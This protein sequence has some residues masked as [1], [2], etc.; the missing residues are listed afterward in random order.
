MRY[1]F[2]MLL[3]MLAFVI[4]FCYMKCEQ[5]MTATAALLQAERN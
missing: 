4:G 1:F 3:F 5:H 2:A